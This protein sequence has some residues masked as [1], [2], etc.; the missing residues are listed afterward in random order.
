MDKAQLLELVRNAGV[1]GAGGVGFPTTC[2]VCS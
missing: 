2:Q 1:V